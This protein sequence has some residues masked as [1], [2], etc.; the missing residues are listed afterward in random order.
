MEIIKG[1]YSAVSRKIDAGDDLRRKEK[2]KKKKSEED[3]SED[4]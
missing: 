1:P 2:D 3:D 4:E